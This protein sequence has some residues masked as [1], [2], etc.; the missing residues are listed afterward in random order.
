MSENLKPDEAENIIDETEIVTND[1]GKTIDSSVLIEE[2]DRTVFLTETE[3]IIIPKEHLIDV[4]PKNRPRKVY[5]GMWGS[6][7]IATVGLAMLAILT[8]IL[9]YVFFVLPRQ[10]ELEANRVKRDK[11]EQEVLSA[12]KKYGDITSTETRVAELI[13]SV[14][15]FETR[16]LRPASISQAAIYQQLNGLI[17][18]YGLTNTTGPDYSPLEINTRS[19]N[20]QQ[21]EKESGRAKFQSLFPGVYIT[22]TVEGSY[23]NLRRL[24]REI[25]TSNQFIVISAVELEA[26]EN[27]EK[28]DS[29]QT[30]ARQQNGQLTDTQNGGFQNTITQST[31]KP[32][33]VRGKTRGE[34]VALRLEMAAYYRR[35]NFQPAQV[36]N[37]E[38]Q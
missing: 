6:A 19:N 37:I 26:A 16:F 31:P 28:D 11:L 33:I 23:Q 21:A 9:M 32:K 1:Y 10:R 20:G 25:E 8:V 12:K 18:A 24:I 38:G 15:D 7:E 22:T 4:V 36:E 3:T 2:A 13:T 29:N 35:P 17:S 27:K 14:N 34:I 30:V 5:G